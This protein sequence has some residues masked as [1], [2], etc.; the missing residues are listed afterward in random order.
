MARASSQIENAQKMPY[1]VN[2]VCIIN[3]KTIAKR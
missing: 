2:L 3:P 1:T